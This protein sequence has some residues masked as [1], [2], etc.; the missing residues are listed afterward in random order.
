MFLY[1]IGAMVEL[2][3][4]KLQSIYLLLHPAI[5]DEQKT[6]ILTTVVSFIVT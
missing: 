4:M 2:K 3:E 5:T 6:K 1:Q